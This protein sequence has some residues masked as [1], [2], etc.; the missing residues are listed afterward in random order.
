MSD[1]INAELRTN[2]VG[3]IDAALRYLREKISEI[4]H[5]VLK[6]WCLEIIES[7]DFQTCTASRKSHQAYDGGL[8]VHT[9]EVLELALNLAASRCMEADADV[10]TTAVIFHDIGKIHDY[11]RIH[12]GHYEYTQHK[13]L[14][15]HL[16]RSYAIFMSRTDPKLSE[17]KRLQIAHCILAHHGRQEWGSPVLPQTPEA[18]AIHCADWISAN[19]TVDYWE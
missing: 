12:D 15:R 18:Y 5:P 9:A 13:E 14:A 17:E 11:E 1:V 8:V 19:A 7:K 3:Q 6:A 16:V 4:C 10:I 2:R